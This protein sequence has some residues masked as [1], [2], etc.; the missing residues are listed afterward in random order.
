MY[1]SQSEACILALEMVF[2]ALPAAFSKLVR[3][4]AY[5]QIAVFHQLYVIVDLFLQRFQRKLVRR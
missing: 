2:P 1:F 3:P 5:G 4:L